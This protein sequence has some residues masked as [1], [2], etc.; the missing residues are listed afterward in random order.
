MYFFFLNHVLTTYVFF[1]LPKSPQYVY[2]HFPEHI[3]IHFQFFVDFNTISRIK[4]I[5][6]NQVFLCE[7]LYSGYFF[8]DKRI[9]RH[10]VGKIN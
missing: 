10:F 2:P 8:L 1:F 4:Y 3:C 5:Y 7:A 6:L 9:Q